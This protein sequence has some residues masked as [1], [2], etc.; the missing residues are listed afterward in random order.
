MNSIKF[1][2]LNSDEEILSFLH[3][4]CEFGPNRLYL[5]I[6]M[7]RPRENESITHNSIPIFREIISREEKIESKYNKLKMLSENHRSDND[8]K[9]TFRF[10]FSTN[11]RDTDKSFYLYQKKLLKMQRYIQNGHEETRKKM[12]RLDQEWKSILQEAGNK[13]DSYFIIDID[14]DDESILKDIHKGLGKE[15]DIIECIRTP[16]GFHLITEPFNPNTD[17]LDE[18]YIDIKRDDLFFLNMK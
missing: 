18:E 2:E 7:A 10:Y 9:L 1:T 4:Y 11:A 14:K 15:T 5:I 16:N 3:D 6:A 12:K 17:I 13:E 8:E